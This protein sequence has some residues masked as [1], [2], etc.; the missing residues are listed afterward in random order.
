MYLLLEYNLSFSTFDTHF[1]SFHTLFHHF[2]LEI[3][4][5][6][7]SAGLHRRYFSLYLLNGFM[8]NFSTGAFNSFYPNYM[9]SAR[10]KIT[11]FW[12]SITCDG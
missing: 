9:L 10:S 11:T 4:F 12:V 3:S 5:T 2:I 6:S 8:P 1:A 7:M